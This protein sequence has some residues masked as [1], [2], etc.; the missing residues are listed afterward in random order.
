MNE[1][2]SS[3]PDS[4][5][6]KFPELRPVKRKPALA[7]VNGI[8]FSM[9]GSRDHDAETRTYVKTHCL[10]FIFVP[11][12]AIGAY[13]VADAERGWYFLG[14]ERLSSFAKSWNIGFLGLAVMFAAIL[15]EHSYKSSPDYRAKQ[16]LKRAAEELNTGRPLEAARVYRNVAEG[17]WH[18]EEGRKGLHDSLETCLASDAPET[19]AAG[20]RFLGAL[21]QRFKSAAPIVPD[22]SARGMILVE[23]FRARNPEGALEILRPVIA[24]GGGTDN[25]LRPLEIELL[26]ETI[27]AKPENINRVV[28]LAVIYE[29][30]EQ[31]RLALRRGGEGEDL[32]WF[33]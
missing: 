11:L 2:K 18:T 30:Q 31:R 19:V 29:E 22:A 13:R 6:Q 1:E 9:F 26:K 14:K 21:P 28:E 20:F 17:Q 32:R 25:S 4:L 7:T 15:A 3:I 27:A 5:R 24:L 12:I 10:C 33:F 16:D 23:K 8:G